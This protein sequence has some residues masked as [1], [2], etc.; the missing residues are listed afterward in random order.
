MAKIS[1][2]TLENCKNFSIFA[3]ISYIGC[4]KE[5]NTRLPCPLCRGHADFLLRAWTR[6]WFQCRQC[7]LRFVP[8][9]QWPS[10]EAEKARYD[11]HRNDA[12][13]YGYVSFLKK[14]FDPLKAK[15]APGASGLD[16]GSG[17]Q[18]VLS[19]IFT[20]AGFPCSAY[21][22]FYAP[23]TDLLSRE[24]D[25]LAC[26]ETIEHFFRPRQEFERFLKLVRPGGWFGI[27]TQLYD[28]A[29]KPF[30]QW[31]YANDITHVCIFARAT[32]QWL[33]KQYGL[34]AEYHPGGVILFRRI[35]KETDEMAGKW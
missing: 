2:K 7:A 4:V 12:F 9:D 34:P 27:M 22:I 31:F 18:P 25:F 17:P 21:D 10:P 15:L 13:N 35:A 32:F 6:D 33:E 24:Y 11:L 5:E 20:D 1:P 8:P 3:K 16:F 26:C 23:E 28:E 19:K 30:D 14:L 29:A